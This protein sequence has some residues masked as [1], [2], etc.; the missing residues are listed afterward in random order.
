[1][2]NV[3]LFRASSTQCVTSEDF[4]RAYVFGANSE[5]VL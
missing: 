5:T 2:M 3:A 1:M 4:A